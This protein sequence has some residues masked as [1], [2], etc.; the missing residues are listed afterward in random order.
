MRGAETLLVKRG[1]GVD[2][3]GDPT[4]DPDT[5]EL[6]NC[7]L[8][9]RESSEDDDRGRVILA[10]WN[11]FIPPGQ[12]EVLATDVIKIRGDDH[13]V[14]GVPGRY[15]MKGRDKGTILVASKTGV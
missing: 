1:A 12:P 4:G 14:V 5:F 13:L 11:V 10:G 8:W 2:W 7:Q 3:Q 6:R 15:D 9:P